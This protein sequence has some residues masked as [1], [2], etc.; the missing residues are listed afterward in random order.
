[1]QLKNRKT[2]KRIKTVFIKAVQEP[3][4]NVIA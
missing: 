2:I 4:E 3:T 1:M